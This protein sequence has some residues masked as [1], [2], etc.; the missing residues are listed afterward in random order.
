MNT[1]HTELNYFMVFVFS[2]NITTGYAQSTWK[3]DVNSFE[4]KWI[5]KGTTEMT[6]YTK[7]GTQL[8][9]F[10]AFDINIT[11]NKDRLSIITQLKMLNSNQTWTGTSISE[12]HT[13]QPVYRS[14][15][16]P[17]R[18]M[19]LQ[20]GKEV[21]GYY[22]DKQLKKETLI[23]ETITSPLLESYTY[24]YLLA[25]LPLTAG[26]KAELLVYDYQTS[27]KTNINKVVIDEV[28]SSSYTSDLTG[29]HPVWYVSV[30][31]VA[32]ND[33]YTYYIDKATRRLWKIEVRSKDQFV[34][35]INKENDQNTITAVLDK[36]QTL[37]MIQ[38]GKSVLAGQAFARDNQ[39][40]G[41]LGGKA[42][43]NIQK[44]QYAAKGVAVILIPYTA[45]FKEWVKL[46][47]SLR[48]KGKAIPLS[49]EA[50]ECIKV[51]TVYDDKGSFEF[52]NLQAGEYLL[53]TE[54]GYIHTSNR[55]EIVGYTDTYI[56]GMFQG[57]AANTET[58]KV[59][60]NAAANIKKIVTIKT[61]GQ[62]ISVKLKKTL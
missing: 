18:R 58:Y 61:D 22:F 36:A 46:N 27:Q 33:H 2:L 11:E 20:F 9:P 50:A 13:L 25:A 60:G 51:A 41:V 26:Y 52:V 55:T 28:K 7:S 49:K 53:Y 29:E 15:F 12:S 62:R 8:I 17:D 45:Y 3:I 30:R 19:V 10:G 23:K 47:E 35:M 56:N 39:N 42:I 54:F 4:K 44:K 40:E 31:E 48:K 38:S 34:L 24:P 43:L 6:C 37:A 1:K 16:T 5:T 21:N 14:S 59:Q 57:S 32:N